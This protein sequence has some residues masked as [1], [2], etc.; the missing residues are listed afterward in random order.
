MKY[1]FKINI[2]TDGDFSLPFVPDGMVY[3][4]YGDYTFEKHY[5]DR[6]KAVEDV[7]KICAFL[8]EHMHTHRDYLKEMWNNHIDNF[9][10]NIK[11]SNAAEYEH[12]EECIYGNYE[13]TEFVFFSKEVYFDSGFYVTDEELE[14]LK[15]NVNNV[16]RDTIKQAVLA[17]FKE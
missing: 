3:G 13:G 1:I 17:L 7:L 15:R 6:D 16:T 10:K 14:I 5:N 11:T 12:I 9:V 4:D 8:K 2:N